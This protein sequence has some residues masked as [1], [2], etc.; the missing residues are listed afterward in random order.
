MKSVLFLLERMPD[1]TKKLKM[2]IKLRLSGVKV[3]Y[4]KLLHESSKFPEPVKGELIVTD[5]QSAYE[6][7]KLRGIEV[8]IYIHEEKELDSYPKAQ[9]LVINPEDTDYEYFERVYRRIHDIPWEIARTKRMIIR[10][11]IEE[12]V[13]E[14]AI[15]YKDSR[16]TKYME[17]LYENIEAEKKYAREYRDKVY[18]CQG[19]GIWTLLDKKTQKCIGRAGLTYRC[20]FDNVEIGFAIGTEYWNKGYASEAIREILAFAERENLGSVN[21]LVMKDNAASRHVLEK[22]DFKYI[23]DTVTSGR[24]YMVYCCQRS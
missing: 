20:G 22:F 13:D 14:F 15:M 2:V 16:M 5:S 11:T 6:Y 18:A 3:S 8:L 4:T 1:L 19:F 10:E 7:Y 17:P 24:E 9:Y 23:E 21:A 12:D